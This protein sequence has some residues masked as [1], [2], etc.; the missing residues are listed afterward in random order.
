MDLRQHNDR[1]FIWHILAKGPKGTTAPYDLT[2]KEL[3]VEIEINRRTVITIDNFE[4]DG[5]TLSFVWY[6]KDQRVTGPFR[7]ILTEN[8]GA[9][10]EHQIDE[11]GPFRL[12][13]SNA[14]IRDRNCPPNIEV[15]AIELSSVVAVFDDSSIPVTVARKTWVNGVL[16]ENYYTK[17]AVDL[18]LAGKQDTIDD[19]G[20]IRSGAAAGATAVQPEAG[21]GLSHNDYSDA[22][23]EKLAGIATGAQVNI[24][25]GVKVNGTDLAID[26]KKV[27]VLVPTKTSDLTNDSDFTT[28]AIVQ[29][30]LAIIN[31]VIPTQ[32]S[33]DNQLADKNFVNSSITT[34]TAE[35]RG[36]Y[37]SPGMIPTTGVDLN[38]YAFVMSADEDG[39]TLYSRYKFNG[40]QWLF[41][42]TI[43]NSY[44]TAAQWAAV[45]SGMTLALVEKL[46]QLPTKQQL[47]E[48]FAGKQNT[49]LDLADLTDSIRALLLRDLGYNAEQ[50]IITLVAGEQGK[51]VKCATRAA[52][53]NASFTISQ[54]FD[55]E[56][57]S[58]LLIKTGF[59]PSDT[60]HAPLD[61]SVIAIYEEMERTRT[62]QKKDGDG[63]PLYYVVTVDPETGTETVT[64]EES[65]VVS[66]FPVYTTETYIEHRYLPNNEDRFVK[67]P[68]SGYYIANIP[69]SC[70]CVISYKPGVTDLNVLVRKHGA[71]A[72]LTS[73][74]FGIYE[75]RVMS[76]AVVNL[77][78]RIEALEARI[79]RPGN[80]SVGAID[81]DK[82]TKFGYPV[83]L[84]GEGAPSA[85]V[86][87]LN[88]ADDLPWDGIPAFLG[89]LYIDVT[90]ATRGL[91]HAKDSTAVSDWIND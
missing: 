80:I 62:V 77:A 19:L 60:N 50:A 45:N 71:L 49:I 13:A 82:L 72:N 74:I 67:I 90:A 33:A 44:F 25:E 43:N 81:I 75:H 87:P 37:M 73:Q 58:E 30:A 53:N 42:F 17:A 40:T 89:Q 47:D 61:L 70:K 2:G 23:K 48:L 79:R 55:V 12:V 83:I 59:N 10:G 64:S 26:G 8:P 36:T 63:N 31:A 56:A 78:A 68:D 20:T 76:E 11:A 15:E 9:I 52:E 3:L 84:I 34:A 69:Q 29:A 18:K 39:N 7:I 66:D 65:T 28:N 51:Y 21:K 6:G 4:V 16:E 1:N 24:L 27:N 88:L 57:C 54:P 41:E 14:E 91:W 22:E 46:Q 32:A 85:S 35:F 5:N 38:D 86:R